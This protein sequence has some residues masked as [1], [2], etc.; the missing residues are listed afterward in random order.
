M[1]VVDVE[2]DDVEFLPSLEHLLEHDQVMG[3]PFG[4]L[5]AQTQC[6]RAR[7]D[8]LGARDRPHA[9]RTVELFLA[10]AW[11]CQ[12]LL[13]SI[14]LSMVPAGGGSLIPDHRTMAALIAVAG[15]GLLV[16]ILVA[17]PRI[18]PL[19]AGLPAAKACTPR[20]TSCR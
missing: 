17:A 3:H 12:W 13:R 7:G 1:Q 5:L 18:S 16:G 9:V 20:L 4:E 10:A 2:V 19:A 8:E 6:L 15:T 11:G 14:S